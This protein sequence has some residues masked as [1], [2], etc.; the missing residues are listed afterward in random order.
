MSFMADYGLLSCK[1]IIHD[2]HKNTA[3]GGL[4]FSTLLMVIL[5]LMPLN[6]TANAAGGEYTGL[7]AGCAS[8][9]PSNDYSLKPTCYISVHRNGAPDIQGTFNG[10]NEFSSN[11][12]N[13]VIQGSGGYST[14]YASYT[15]G[16]A[17]FCASNSYGCNGDY[18]SGSYSTTGVLSFSLKNPPVSTASVMQMPTTGAPDGLTAVGVTAIGF[19]ILGLAFAGL[20]R[21][22]W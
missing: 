12:Q 18:V 17:K 6:T 3:G 4:A 9:Q 16:P 1:E 15:N 20:R 2:S 14:V 21:Q 5:V 11:L 22:R 8:S 13:I 19:G 7:S 10:D